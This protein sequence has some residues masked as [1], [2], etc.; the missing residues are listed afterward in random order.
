MTLTVLQTLLR[1]VVR[2]NRDVTSSHSSSASHRSPHCVLRVFLNA[3]G[4]EG[5]C[6]GV[7]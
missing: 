5:H 2:G 6:G 7:M 4:G 1:A 3:E